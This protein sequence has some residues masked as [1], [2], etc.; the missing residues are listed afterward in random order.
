[1]RSLMHR[2]RKGV[3]DRIQ[4]GG[5]RPRWRMVAVAAV[6]AGGLAFCTP[7]PLFYAAA[8]GG[9]A[10]DGQ[11]VGQGADGQGTAGQAAASQDPVALDASYGYDNTA[12]GGRY[13]PLEVIVHNR[14]D[15]VLSGTLQVKSRESDGTIYRYDY[16]VEVG[17]LSEL[18]E[19]YY[20]PLGTHADQLF[21]TLAAP[22]GSVILN[23]RLRLNISLDVP[24]LFIGILSDQ[25][26]S[27]R[28]LNGAGINYSALRTR[29]FA[30]PEGDFPEE[31]IGL[32]LLD[33]IIVNS[34]RLRSL[35][36]KQTAAIMDWVYNGGVLILG[37]GE[38]VDDTL[39]RFAPELLD[40]SYG[41]AE[42]R[43]VNM[44]EGWTIDNP[45][46]AVLQLPCVD[47]PL[48]GGNVIFSSGGS[49]LLTA[50]AKG[51]GLIAVASFDFADIAGFCGNQ[52]AY[53][54]RLFTT[55]L[56]EERVKALVQ[57]AYNG[58][59][60]KFLSV[61]SL[62]NTG[63]V[64]K[65]PN[66]PLY[67]GIIVVYLGLLGPGLYLYF[68]NRDLQIFYR[69]GVIILSLCFA[70]VIYLVGGK[71][72]FKST[73]YTYAAIQD[74]TAD[75][76]TDTTYVNVRNPYNRPYTVELAPDYSVLPITRTS[77][78]GR[79]AGEFTGEED[80]LIAI[81]RQD[82]RT[83]IKGQNVV[84]FAPRYFRLERK[85]DNTS[86]IGISGEVDYFE[87][88]LSG[89]ITNQF[90]F[91][92]ENTCLLLYGNMVMLDRLEPGETRPL[93]ELELLR[94]PLNNFYAV[95]EY[96]TGNGETL[97]TN[98]DDTAYLLAMERSNMLTFYL[99]SYMSGYSADAR[100]IAFST[101]KEESQFLKTPSQ[102]TYGLTMLT[103]SI[104]VNASR[105]RSLYRS[106]LMKTPKVITGEYQADTN[107]MTG[108]DP[109]T[110]EYFL[111]NDIDVE[112]L[113]FEP[114][115]GKFT[116]D[117]G[118]YNAVFE[119]SIYFYNY[120]TGNYDLMELDGKTLDMDGLLPYLS[121]DNAMTVRYV[122]SR[123]G[124]YNDIQLPMPMVA[125]RER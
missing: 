52:P 58:D 24:E 91:P 30:L 87:G 39:G 83:T 5:G 79:V 119:G 44:A 124:G 23:K 108:S 116:G 29:T 71:T 81:S 69:R 11:M 35:S 36:E 21:L 57:T 37:T 101:Q 114:V 41:S 28:Y 18:T 88:K 122:Y 72:R 4:S 92:L 96:I 40:D 34:F 3:V 17:A 54:D 115:S 6:L 42:L 74:V 86:R 102:E 105:D 84:A 82:D 120:R 47:I 61:Q 107:S 121:E 85:M 20:I 33:V 98:I 55:L 110:L 10:A 100:V 8:A 7:G 75:Y 26:G 78:S 89:S 63:N 113:T 94:F 19:K 118:S 80:Y 70:V 66:L 62:I 59:T 14:Q 109:V 56:G 9:Q 67:T 53:V 73:F 97:T 111:G 68:K 60:G 95:A 25:P 76:V 1:M 13:L 50:A 125:G 106:V 93:D 32:N 104:A 123:A 31:E 38:R 46:D 103:S 12:K 16:P 15:T 27:L 2:P 99:R 22:D 77:S 48:H 112:S 65:L 117:S 45:Q 64:D 49:A 90:P 51:N 43:T